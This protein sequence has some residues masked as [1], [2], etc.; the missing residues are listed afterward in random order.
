MLRTVLRM[1]LEGLQ[2]LQFRAQQPN[3]P[4]HRTQTNFATKRILKYVPVQR[5]CYTASTNF[6]EVNYG[7]TILLKLNL[8]R[9]KITNPY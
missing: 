3:V 5:A 2:S 1:I 7:R 9:A 4:A 6:S 8:N